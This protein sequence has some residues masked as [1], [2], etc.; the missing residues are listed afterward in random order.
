V[1]AFDAILEVCYA[2]MGTVK[3][4]MAIKEEERSEVQ[5]KEL[6]HAY[7]G[8]KVAL[9][10]I[11]PIISSKPLFESGQTLLLVTNEKK[12]TDPEY[13]ET[14][15][16]LVRLRTAI[17]PLVRDLWEAPWLISAPLHVSKSMV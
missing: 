5:K 12:D 13:F 14:H 9:H 1:G 8:L 2:F 15:N 11:R 16:F 4:I 7:G 3:T 6:V 10:L 17:L